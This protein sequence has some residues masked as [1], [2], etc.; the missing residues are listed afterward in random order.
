MGCLTDCCLCPLLFWPALIGGAAY[1][2][3][4]YM[5]GGQ[6]TKQTDETGKVFIV[7]GSNTGIGKETVLEIAKRG[8]T[9]Y[10]ACRDMNRCEKAR[11][12]IIRESGNKNI[13]ARELDL[14]S[15]ESIRKFAAGFKK[16]QDK[17]HVLINNA[18]VMHCPR[19]LT[20]DGFEMQLGVN[21][22]GHFLLTHLLLDVLKK[23]AP[24]R[25]V[26]VSSGAHTHGSINVDDLNS[27]K[28]YGKIAAYT[29]SKVANILFT[30][31]LAKRLEGTGVTVNSLHPGAVDTE[32]MR[33]WSFMENSL[34]AFLVKPLQWTL[35]KT[36]RSGA[37]T[38][39]YAALD[40]EL[41]N[42]SGLYF[43]DCKAKDVSAAA[44][45]DKAGKFLWAESEKWTGV[46][47][48]KLD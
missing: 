47:T 31:E 15:L 46:N 19:T 44:K 4:K 36:P 25:I 43:S 38:S 20:K 13:F 11:Q 42:V 7:T 35:F 32:L 39:L 45:D 9:V 37:Q 40:P 30:R 5:Q 26:V 34:I 3:R 22:M 2:L 29:Q 23:T 12:D 28:S 24:S 21:H 41:K 16:E 17:L 18:G 10:M 6:F 27:E 48:S 14:S 1:F 8:G 33:Y